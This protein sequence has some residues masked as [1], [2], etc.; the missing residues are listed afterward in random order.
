MDIKGTWYNELG[1]KMVIDP[2]SNG[3]ITGTYVTAVSST[4]CAKGNFGLVG[5]TDTD[6]GGEAV[7]FVVRWQNDNSNCESVTAWSGQAQ[8]VNGEDQI[9][10]FWLLT[11]ESAPDQDWYATH[12][13]QDVFTRVQPSASH[14]AK[15]LKTARL[16]HP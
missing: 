12:V 15:K 4:G 6:T 7:A 16:A 8:T 13:G 14:V 10:A 3:Q 9:N 2:V 1:S 5:L 11:V